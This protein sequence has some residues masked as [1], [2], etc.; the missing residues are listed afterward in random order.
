LKLRKQG[1][2]VD[3]DICKRGISKNLNYANT[4][5]IPYVI[6]IG[7]EELKDK[8]VKLKNMKTG[9]EELVEVDD[10]KKNIKL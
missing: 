4:Y 6:F 2:N 5:D 10:I 7:E 8:K 9:K 1:F 3:I